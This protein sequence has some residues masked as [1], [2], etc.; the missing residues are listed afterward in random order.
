MGFAEDDGAEV[1]G[2]ADGQGHGAEVVCAAE[3]QGY[4]AEVV[5]AAEGQG[6]GAE[7]MEY[8]CSNF[9]RLRLHTRLGEV[10]GSAEDDVA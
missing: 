8:S 5:G 3:G 1:V 4:G 9:S 7:V 6:Y 10:I 2:A